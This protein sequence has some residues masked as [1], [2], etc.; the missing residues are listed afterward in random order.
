MYEYIGKNLSSLPD[1]SIIIAAKEGLQAQL[2]APC[3]PIPLGMSTL[4]MTG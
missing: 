1:F 4:R 3:L 2:E